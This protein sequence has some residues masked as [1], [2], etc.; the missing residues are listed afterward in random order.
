MNTVVFSTNGH[1]DYEFF[2]PLAAHAWRVFGWEPLI[3]TLGL[4]DLV[5]ATLRE[6]NVRCAPI[7]PVLALECHAIT[8][9]QTCRLYLAAAQPD[10]TY[11]MTS[12]VDM[13][14]LSDF[15][16]KDGKNRIT[17]WDITGYPKEAAQVP[18][19]YVQATGAVW[20]EMMRPAA[21]CD[22][23]EATVAGVGEIPGGVKGR[24]DADQEL[25]TA[26]VRAYGEH[27]F[28]KFMRYDRAGIGRVCRSGWNEG[29]ARLARTPQIDCHALR[30]GHTQWDQISFVMK[31]AGIF[32]DWMD[33][34]AADYCN[35][36]SVEVS[37]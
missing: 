2:A 35:A 34:Y 4:T 17:G 37:Q 7:E 20:K 36:R 22:W 21:D 5:A 26:R 28:E 25:L 13:L 11:V 9:V 1:R 6:H 14:P 8:A 16:P 12:D 24:W 19:C 32:A 31:T 27:R 30:P 10:N 15:W 33:T 3:G 29:V 23:L 18:I